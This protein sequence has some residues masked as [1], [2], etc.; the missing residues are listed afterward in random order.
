MT[1]FI[2]PVSNDQATNLNQLIEALTD[3]GKNNL[4][5]YKTV[6]ELINKLEANYEDEISNE[7]DLIENSLQI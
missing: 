7:N 1:T 5:I 2:N 4:K 3:I 6:E